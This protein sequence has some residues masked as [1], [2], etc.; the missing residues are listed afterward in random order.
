[1]SELFSDRYKH[2]VLVMPGCE[3]YER[4]ELRAPAKW[5]PISSWGRDGWDLGDWPY[6][7]I[8]WRESE[9]HELL[10]DVEGESTVYL[11][12][13]PELRTQ[14][15]DELALF[16]W[17]AHSESWVEGIESVEQMPAFLR[18]PY[19]STR[20]EEDRCPA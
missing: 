3:G 20:S 17:R 4:M 18:G 14:A 9:G 7:V 6:V 10:Y 11:Y 19:S 13:T 5:R 1:M 16:Y 12:P 2:N 15:T 8:S